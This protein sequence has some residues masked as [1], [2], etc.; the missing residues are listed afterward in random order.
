MNNIAA[1]TPK[2]VIN[3]IYRD[4]NLK[5][6]QSRYECHY[7]YV[8]ESGQFRKNKIELNFVFTCIGI[9]LFLAIDSFDRP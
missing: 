7:Y 3:I 4:L 1:P 2:S 5:K 8:N 6:P 9:K